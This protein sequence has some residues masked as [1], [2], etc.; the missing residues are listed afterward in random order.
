MDTN[1]KDAE[2]GDEFN[3]NNDDDD[4]TSTLM[5]NAIMIKTT[6]IMIVIATV[7][8][9]YEDDYEYQ[10]SVL[11]TRCTFVG[12]QFLK[13]ACSEL[14]TCTCSRPRTPF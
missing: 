12:R 3:D 10:F 13:C 14:K 1:D 8:L 2:N 7:R 6:V 5:M 4:A 11:S 9:E